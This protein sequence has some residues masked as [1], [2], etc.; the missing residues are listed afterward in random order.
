M[1]GSAPKSCLEAWWENQWQVADL[2][3]SISRGEG[4]CRVT[5]PP[6]TGWHVAGAG[7]GANGVLKD[8]SLP[9]PHP[10]YNSM[11]NSGYWFMREA[12]VA[13]VFICSQ[14]REN[15]DK[16]TFGTIQYRYF[17]ELLL[18]AIIFPFMLSIYLS[19]DLQ[20]VQCM[21]YF[22]NK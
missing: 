16:K 19:I 21:H 10:R 6:R 17:F 11:R 2:C 20:S 3:H 8:L 22:L 13:S 12:S 15:W 18:F 7:R 14:E 5:Q 9:H 4:S 1:T